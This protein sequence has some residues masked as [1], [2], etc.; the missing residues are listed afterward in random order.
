MATQTHGNEDFMRANLLR[1]WELYDKTPRM[2][3]FD[4][5]AGEKLSSDQLYERAAMASGL[6]LPL[7]TPEY[8]TV[9]L[10]DMYEAFNKQYKGQKRTLQFRMSDEAFINDKYGIVRA[11]GTLLAGVFT[12]AKEIAAAIYLNGAT[13]TSLIV[14]PDGVALS[15]ASHPLE[16][17]T[18]TNTFTTQQTLGIIALED[19]TTALMNQKAHKGYQQP[20]YGPFQLEVA[21]R[22][23]HLSAR[24]IGADK[25]PGTPNNDP[26]SLAGKAG[27]RVMGTVQKRIVSPYFN[28][29]EWWCLRS[30]DDSQQPRFMLNRYGY[31]LTELKYDGD[32]DSWKVTA[33]E[34]YLF[35]VFD[36]RGTFYST[37]N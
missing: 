34:N 25:F 12:T 22:N 4:A 2:T 28:N 37:P 1:A 17:G 27:D 16:T 20:K 33:K 13:D 15:S 7:V 21:P 26:N 35:D 30:I 5:L 9:P 32:N 31:K 3:F 36:Y 8:G 11:Y 10:T 24:L 6:A 18:D 14:G 23:N 19:A 29:A